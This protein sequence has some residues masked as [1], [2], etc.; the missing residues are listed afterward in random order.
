MNSVDKYE[1]ADEQKESKNMTD[2][3]KIFE[4]S[5]IWKEAEYNFA[6]WNKFDKNFNW[7]RCSSQ[8]EISKF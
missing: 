3:Q 4:L 5:L 7:L 6:F 8:A 1:K 2:E